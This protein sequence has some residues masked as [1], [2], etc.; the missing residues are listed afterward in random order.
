MLLT[1]G[2]QKIIN[3]ITTVTVFGSL[4]LVS[5]EKI[6]QP[7]KRV[8]DSHLKAGQKFSAAGLIFNLLPDVWKG[9]Q[10]WSFVFDVL[11]TTGIQE[12]STFSNTEKR[13]ETRGLALSYEINYGHLQIVPLLQTD[14][15]SENFSMISKLKLWPNGVASRRKL[16]TWVYLGLRLGRPC[17]HL[18]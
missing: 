15:I 5:I 18:R 17:V 14:G 1:T 8:I 7:L 11:H 12:N 2:I 10:T 4:I 6:Y 16:K 3:E 13:V 9:D